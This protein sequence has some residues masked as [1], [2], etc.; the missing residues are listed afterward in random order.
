LFYFYPTQVGAGDQKIFDINTFYP[1]IKADNQ[2]LPRTILLDPSILADVKKAIK[3]NDDDN[4]DDNGDSDD[5]NDSNT[6]LQDSLKELLHHANSFITK[7]PTSV[8]ERHNHHQVVINMT[9]FPY[10]LMSGQIHPNQMVPYI[11][12][13]G[14]V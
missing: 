13:D 11:G 12:R 6:I 14:I 7:T 1:E 2:G 8:M 9:I 5:N 4:D 10:L 3:N